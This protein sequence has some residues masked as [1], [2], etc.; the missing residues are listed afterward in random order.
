MSIDTVKNVRLVNVTDA[1]IKKSFRKL[2]LK[3]H[4]DVNKDPGSRERFTEIREAYKVLSMPSSRAAYDSLQG[5]SEKK[6]RVAAAKR[7]KA[8]NAAAQ[9]AR[10]AKSASSG[11]TSYASRKYATGAPK[12]KSPPKPKPKPKPEDEFYGVDDLF[13]DLSSDWEKERKKAE[14]KKE[15]TAR[16]R[17]WFEDLLDFLE[18]SAPGI[19]DG[20]DGSSASAS[21]SYRPPPSRSAPPR[22]RASSSWQQPKAQQEQRQQQRRQS[23]PPPPSRQPSGGGG[24]GS[25]PWRQTPKRAE[26]DV[27]EMLAQLKKEMGID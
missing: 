17:S 16:R 5:I 20:Y 27:D 26:A 11:Y 21:A 24:G 8:R 3:Y 1:E 6:K 10:A 18:E 19:E 25:Q 4:P 15:E 22:Q 13:R 23:P 12:P 7:A 14:E 2:V 9:R